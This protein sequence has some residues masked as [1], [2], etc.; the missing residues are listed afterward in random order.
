[1]EMQELHEQILED[2]KLNS[3]LE[4]TTHV[5]ELIRYISDVMIDAE[6]IE[7][8]NY[9]LYEGTGKRGKLIQ[10]DAYSYNE[11]DNILSL[12]ICPEVTYGDVETITS[13]EA[14]KIFAKATAFINEAQFICENAEE[15]TPGYG[16]AYDILHQYRFVRKYRIYLLTDKVMSSKIKDIKADSINDITTEFNIWDLGRIL[17]ILQSGMSKEEIVINLCEFV[18]KGLP[19]L[20]A[21][22]TNDYSAYLC[23]IPGML[24]ANLYNMYGGRLLEG[25]VRSFLQTKGKV[26][27]GI[28]TTILNNPTMFFAYNNG[29]AATASNIKTEV[30]DG[31]LSITE[32]TG[33]QI[34]NGGQTT[35]SLANSLLND[36]KDN[37]EKQIAKIYVP[38]K[39]S[40]VDTE[41]AQEIIPNISRFANSQNKVSEADLWSNHPFHIR[42]EDFS[43]KTVAPA[44]DGKQFGTYWYYERANGQYKQETYKLTAKER[45]KFEMSHPSSQMFKKTDLAKYWNIMNQRPDIASAGGTKSF[46]KFAQYITTNWDKDNTQF[47]IDFFQQIV[48]LAIMFKATDHIVKNQP[49]YNSYKANIVAYTVSKLIYTIETDY[50]GYAV[51]YHSIWLKQAIPSSWE[52]QITI[53]SKIIYDHL[54][55]EA[56]QV[57]NVTEWAKRELCW[58]QTKNIKI[59]LIPEFEESL[60]LKMNEKQSKKD[61][62]KDQKLTNA[63]EDMKAVVLYGSQ[64][65][66]E[67]LTWNDAH[68]VLGMKEIDLI[69]VATRIELGKM[70]SEKQCVL[71][72]KI[73]GH[74]REE[75]FPK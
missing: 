45:K 4:G 15:S 16:L 17:Q 49:W 48:S 50:P 44:V 1:M 61:A 40:V 19:C 52:K 54:I 34:V 11:L 27:K 57:E 62:K 47:N 10:V 41:K 46:S 32:I 75:G 21:S 72:M 8:I 23:N 51:P 63:I 12:F 30:I 13:S 33:L 55:D 2:I 24:L 20:P 65:W 74:A 18:D 36:K 60:E 71:I 37:S 9:T 64:G 38:M 5:E 3:S 73:L 69:K 39:L 26:N 14:D 66:K 7:D 29:I 70:P 35:A 59:Q 53:T 68:H 25:N 31:V 28:R 58:E 56:R 22:K 6:E 43:R 42:L 67:L